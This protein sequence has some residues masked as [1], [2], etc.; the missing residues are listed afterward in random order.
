MNFS[1]LSIKNPVPAIMLFILLTLAG[2]LAFKATLVQDF[3]DIDMPAVM[4]TAVLEGAAPAQLETEVARKIEDAVATLEA[5]KHLHTTIRDGE[6]SVMV[7]FT[8][9]KNTAEAVNDVR[10]AI[11][12]VRADLPQD[13]RNPIVTKVN[14]AGRAVL[15]FSASSNKLDEQEVTWFVDNTVTKKLLSVT[16]V[17]AVKRLGG[18]NREVRI[19]LDATKMS[20]LK[21]T[22]LDVSRQLKLVQ[23]ENSGGRGDVS[24]V[25]QNV[26][27]IATVK[28][29]AE[30]AAIQLPLPAKNGINLHVRLDQVAD[31]T[32][33]FAERRSIALKNGK[34]VIGIEILRTRGASE[35]KVAAGV[36]A[37]IA[38]LQQEHPNVNLAL[39]IDNAAPVE[40][41]FVGSMNM[42]YEGAI[43]AV[44]VVWWFLRD[45]RATL[46]AAVALP[47]SVIPTFLGMYYFGFTLNT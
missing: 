27:T 18:V 8:L 19:E 29:V 7:E 10:S 47:L 44:L 26:R 39:E 38:Q 25:E 9:E 21:L 30:L 16:G 15:V 2:L 37:A 31:V 46:I 36:Q 4:V 42:L 14:N 20:A 35:V 32:D 43:L 33:T 41:N 12:R 22:A 23:Q 3:P 13:L 24:G 5:V 11:D 28:S 1:A 40:E 6:V 45:W 34:P 17:G